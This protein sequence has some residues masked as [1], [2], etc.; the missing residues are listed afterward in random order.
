M[1]L[2]EEVQPRAALREVR[3]DGWMFVT[4]RE[5]QDLARRQPGLPRGPQALASGPLGGPEERYGGEQRPYS[6]GREEEGTAGGEAETWHA[7]SPGGPPRN[8]RISRPAPAGAEALLPPLGSCPAAP[9]RGISLRLCH[10]RRLSQERSAPAMEGGHVGRYRLSAAGSP[11]H[12]EIGLYAA[13]ALALLGIAALNLWKLWRSASYPAPSPF[14]NYDYR[15]LEQKYGAAYSEVKHK[16]GAAAGSRRATEKP[17]PAARANL[18]AADTLESINELGGLELMSRELGLAPDGALRKSVSADSLN[19]VSSI[20]N[21]FGQDGTVGQVEVSLEYAGRSHALRVA[22]LQGKD[23]LDKADVRFES[24]FVRI[25][26]LP[27]EQIVGISRVS[28]AGGPPPAAR[29]PG[30]RSG[31]VFATGGRF[32]RDVHPAAGPPGFFAPNRFTRLG[33][34][35]RSAYSVCF[36]ERFSIPLDP[37]ALEED[38][39]RF[40]VFGIDEDERNVSTG[41]A[42]LK[43]SD[44]DLPARPFNAW[45]YLQDVNKAVDSVGDILLSLSYLPTAERLTVVVVKAKNLVWTNGKGTAG[46]EEDQQEE[47]G[48]EERRP[49]PRLQRGHDLLGAGH[50]AAEAPAARRRRLAGAVAAGDGGGVRRGRPSRQHGPRAHRPGGQRHGHHPLEPDVGH[51]EEARV[52]VAPGPAQLGAR[53]RPTRG[54]ASAAQRGAGAKGSALPRS[55]S[56]PV[57]CR[58]WGENRERCWATRRGFSWARAGFGPLYRRGSVAGANKENG[59]NNAGKRGGKKKKKR[60]D[61]FGFFCS[62]PRLSSFFPILL[63]LCFSLGRPGR[64]QSRGDERPDESRVIDGPSAAWV[65]ALAGRRGA[66]ADV[67][68]EEAGEVGGDKKEA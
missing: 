28:G 23:L 57:G 58:R 65:C 63:N 19:S 64:E 33:Q 44:L 25:S 27:D 41:V 13:G 14:P 30:G 11:P 54:A 52:H 45:L 6:L 40:S 53:R 2:G 22:L 21:N 31:S 39:L 16:R 4:N 37:A 8:C 36:D 60:L 29:H 3:I 20:G 61:L 35:Q 1:P 56:E 32:S 5:R 55:P 12:W 48:G 17:A 49:E 24:C 59:T 68:A 7:G 42:E 46:R 10:P 66:G 47:D 50:R 34:I 26:L 38:S 18:K 51:A 67:A 62:S 15:Y 9:P 43:L